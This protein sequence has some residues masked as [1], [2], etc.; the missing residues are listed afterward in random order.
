MTGKLERKFLAH[1]LDVNFNVG[2]KNYVRLGQDLES[3]GEELNPQV[4]VRRNI[5]GEQNVTHSGYQVQ[6]SAEPF[7]AYEGDPLFNQLSLIANERRT[8]DACMTTRVEVLVNEAG[9]VLWAY[10]ENCWVVPNSVGGDTTGVQIPFT[11]YNSGGRVPG[12]WD[13]S[14]KAFTP[15]AVSLNKT[16]A[17]ITVAA[18]DDHTV[19]L[20]ATTTPA[21]QTVTWASSDTSVA[22]VANGT[23]TAVAV[24]S[25][26]VTATYKSVSAA[27]AITVVAGT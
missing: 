17:E 10:R 27:C 12:L 11:V 21:G 5:L 2:E 18:G 8:G 14:S 13:T 15:I 20:T 3:Y 22:T 16:E 1:Y 25:C 4:D 26:V 6:S 9:T 23:V 7:Y 19:A 24:G